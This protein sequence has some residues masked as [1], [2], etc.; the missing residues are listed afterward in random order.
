MLL[1]QSEVGKCIFVAGIHYIAICIYIYIAYILYIA[2]A[3]AAIVAIL[4]VVD[5]GISTW[6]TLSMDPS[7]I[8]SV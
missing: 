3:A 5:H 4:V 1:S 2:T 8:V 6:S 7:F